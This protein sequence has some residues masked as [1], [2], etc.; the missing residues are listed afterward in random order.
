MIYIGI[1]P[2]VKTGYAVWSP[3]SKSFKEIGAGHML[4]IMNIVLRTCRLDDHMVIIEDARKRKKFDRK[5][6]DPKKYQGVGS[7]KRDCQLWEEFCQMNAINFIMRH[8][9]NTKTTAESFK[10]M[11]GYNKSTNEHSRDAAM[12]V[13]GLTPNSKIIL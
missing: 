3:Y 1:D 11:T 8:P 10:K 5:D 9:R 13:Y 7:V 2:G 4:T 12:I 6:W